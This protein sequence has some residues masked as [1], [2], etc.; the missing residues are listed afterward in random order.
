MNM[1]ELTGMLSKS[2]KASDMIAVRKLFADLYPF[3]YKNSSEPIPAEFVGGLLK[4]LDD[5]CRERH[6]SYDE[7]AV[8][9]ALLP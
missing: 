8:A 3:Y 2:F 7:D 1:H 4:R 5:F 6:I 9:K